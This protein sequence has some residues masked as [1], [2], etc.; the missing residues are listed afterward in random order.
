MTDFIKRE[1]AIKGK[2]AQTLNANAEFMM[3]RICN[4]DESRIYSIGFAEGWNAHI[5]RC[6][7]IPSAESK[8]GEWIPCSERLPSK[9]VPVL[10]NGIME[11]APPITISDDA[12]LYYESGWINAWMPLLDRC[13]GADNEHD[14]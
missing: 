8:Q 5:E 10:V 13:K 3:G 14:K 4:E 11:D 7:D 6:K 2:Q 9:G 1:D 12:P